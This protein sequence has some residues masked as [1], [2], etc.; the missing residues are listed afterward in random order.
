[1]HAA[2]YYTKCLAQTFSRCL[3]RHSVHSQGAEGGAVACHI[4]PAANAAT[5]I[6]LQLWQ[7]STEG[8]VP[9]ALTV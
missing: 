8:M 3:R 1:M 4:Y 6:A 5:L 2:T 7:R 9:Q